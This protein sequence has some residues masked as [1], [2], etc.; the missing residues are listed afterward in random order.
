M[1]FNTTHSSYMNRCRF[2]LIWWAA[3]L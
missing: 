3:A 1:T 2:L